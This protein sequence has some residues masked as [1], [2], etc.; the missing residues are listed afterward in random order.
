MDIVT[1]LKQILARGSADGDDLEAVTH[2]LLVM[3][4][5]S[6]DD[7]DLLGL[8]LGLHNARKTHSVVPLHRKLRRLIAEAIERL[9]HETSQETA[10]RMRRLATSERIQRMVVCAVVRPDEVEDIRWV[11][12]ARGSDPSA[13]AD[14]DFLACLYREVAAAATICEPYFLSEKQRICLL[15]EAESLVISAD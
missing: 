14:D 12:Q 2:A 7:S 11:L 10:N 3:C 8:Y 9:Q 15:F 6:E 13:V 1:R 5:S 4:V